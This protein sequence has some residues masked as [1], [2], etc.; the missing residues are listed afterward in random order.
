MQYI[1]GTRYGA[2]TIRI[3]VTALKSCIVYIWVRD[4][5]TPNTYL[6]KRFYP[7]APGQ[8]QTFD[9]QM[10]I[11]GQNTITEIFDNPDDKNAVSENFKVG[12]VTKLSLAKQIRITKLS[13]QKVK[14]FVEFAQRF[15]FNASVL[16]TNKPGEVYKSKKGD[17][18]ILYSPTITDQGSTEQLTPARISI[19]TKTIEVSK[20]KFMEMTVP[21]RFCILC[22]EFSHLYQNVDMYDEL[23]A[24]L[25]GLTI[26]L[27]LGYPRYE[28]NETFLKTFYQSP[29]DTNMERYRYIETFI[30]DFETLN[31]THL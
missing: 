25:N 21:M 24:D 11:T 14:D 7:F 17:F 5:K 18:K 26:Y 23:E 15:C 13:S 9:V 3:P 16:P 30:N 10:P 1:T 29:T 22:H 28:A 2:C 19:D 31:F 8:S 4:A 6:L 27:G 12:R 20:A